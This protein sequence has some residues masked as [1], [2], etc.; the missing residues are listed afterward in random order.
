V[1]RRREGELTP[2]QAEALRKLSDGP[3]QSWVFG[4]TTVSVLRRLGLI[5]TRVTQVG[6][7]TQ[8]AEHITDAGRAALR[9][10]K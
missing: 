10:G 5:E 3:L 1:V 4:S 9:G 8:K 7:W 6:N 2:K